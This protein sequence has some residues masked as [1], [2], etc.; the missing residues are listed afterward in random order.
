MKSCIFLLADGAR[1][2]VFAE[3]LERGDLPNISR[4]MIERGTYRN[5][6]SVF[7]STTGPA[8][9][10]FLLGRFPGRCNLP[11]IRWFDRNIYSKKLFSLFRFRSY[12]GL[13]APLMKYDISKE[14]PT[15]FEIL[16]NTV[17]LMNE[18]TRG[19]SSKGNRTR[20]CSM[21]RKV[22]AHYDDSWD[23]IDVAVRHTLLE[24]LN[25]TTQF[26]YCVFMSIDHFSHVNHPFH[27]EVIDGYRRLDDTVG[28]LVK[29][30]EETGRATETLL[31][32][33]SD[34]GLTPAHTHF[35]S[36]EF[37]VR[38]GYKTLY[39]PM[40]FKHFRDAEAANM[41]SGNS[42][43][44]L[45]VKSPDGWGRPTTFGELSGLVDD[46]LEE[47]AV[48]IVA[49]RDEAGVVRIKSERGEA[50][51]WID[52]QRGIV[53]E[54]LEG[55][56]FG[57]N[58][59]SGAMSPYEAV[60]NTARTGYP[61]GI[62]QVIQLFDSPRTGDLVVSAAKGFDLRARYENPEHRSTHGALYREH[63][64]VPFAINAKINR[65]FVRTADLFPTVLK[66]LGVEPPTE[67]DG[68]N[69]ID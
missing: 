47:K 31:I 55:D 16:P 35:D 2:D 13:E 52:E 28:Q 64:L 4:Y 42:M 18:L 49:G 3:L 22:K 38:Q 24:S 19:L 7:P 58:D 12:I 9:T 15:I 10:P 56:P 44:H 54:P 27:Q 20:F 45:Y 25:G 60:A 63:M 21:W 48:D 37:M 46:L 36:V 1:A 5:A 39:Y 57:Y 67:I 23:K 30:L 33:T 11:G 69:L 66:Y 34:H 43:T 62:L 40:V 29:S 41:V 8:Y 65:E 68:E 32:V 6:V 53:Y 17:S 59:L 61:D 26:T 14:Y 50:R 51:A